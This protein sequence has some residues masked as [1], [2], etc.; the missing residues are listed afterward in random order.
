MRRKHRRSFR[1]ARSK[2]VETAAQR[3][4]LSMSGFELLENRSLLAANLFVD[5]GDNFPRGT[6]TTTQGAFRDVADDPVDGNRILGTTLVDSANNFNAGTQLDIVRQT[7]S[8]TSRE[9]MMAVVRRAYEALD[10]NV[11]ELTGTPVTTADGR[12]VSG[13]ANMTDV[14]NTL[15]GGNAGWKDAYIFVATFIVDPGGAAQ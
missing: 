14:V 8:A 10:V 1:F 4:K 15:R 7:F 12:S 9:R 13:A 5:W 11:V 2:K 6:L 3:N